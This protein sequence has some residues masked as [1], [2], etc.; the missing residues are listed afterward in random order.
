MRIGPVQARLL[1]V[2]GTEPTTARQLADQLGIRPASVHDALANL[3]TSGMVAREGENPYRFRRIPERRFVLTLTAE[4]DDR[5]GIAAALRQLLT[6]TPADQDGAG[7]CPVPGGRY[8]AELIDRG[9]R[10]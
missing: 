6:D 5:E 1:G 10:G 9:H 3:I 4:A 7:F 8:R 2:L